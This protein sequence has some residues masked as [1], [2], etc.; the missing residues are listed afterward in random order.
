[1]LQLDAEI[2]EKFSGGTLAGW[3]DKGSGSAPPPGS[4][5]GPL[6]LPAAGIDLE[7]FDS[8]EEVMTLGGS[9]LSART[10]CVCVCAC[11]WLG[12]MSGVGLVSGLEV[13]HYTIMLCVLGW[14]HV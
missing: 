10:V 5:G 6:A 14:F 2:E 9:A 12:L 13:N 4:N 11:I 8:V 7:A 1:M 3:E